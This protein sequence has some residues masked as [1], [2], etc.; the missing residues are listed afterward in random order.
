MKNVMFKF[1]IVLLLLASQISNAQVS[2][3]LNDIE[4]SDSIDEIEKKLNKISNKV[5]IYRIF[6][7][8]FPLSNYKEEHLVASKVNTKN[9]VIDKIVFTF[10]D[11]KL[12]YIQAKGNVSKEFN[13]KVKNALVNYLDFKVYNSDSLHIKLEAD[14]TWILSPESVHLNLFTWDN[15]YLKCDQ[16]DE[17]KYI[18]SVKIPSFI[19]MGKSKKVL[20]AYLKDNSVLNYVEKLEKTD[21]NTKAQINFWGVEFAGFPRK[22]EARFEN[23][24]LNM[25]WIITGKGEE[26]SLR[27]KLTNKYGK[28]S[29]I[30]KDWE[31][32]NNWTVLL[33]KDKPEILLL[34]KDLGEKYK[35]KYLK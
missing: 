25:V 18:Q 20:L 3:I 2:T 11:D 15:P 10:S 16:P 26:N 31:V 27:K 28:A 24:K 13:K 1:S 23:D 9:G 34:S 30:N 7:P 12:S 8:S 6:T 19:Q 14:I 17:I 35:N 4:L 29:F 21:F 32:Y 22:F 5:A 33:R